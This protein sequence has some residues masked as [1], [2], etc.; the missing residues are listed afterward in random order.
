M[1][2]WPQVTIFYCAHNQ[3]ADF[4]EMKDPLDAA[5]DAVWRLGARPVVLIE[6]GGYV[7]PT[8]RF[9]AERWQ[10]KRE[11]P[12]YRSGIF[13]YPAARAYNYGTYLFVQW[14][15]A[16]IEHGIVYDTPSNPFHK[17]RD[18]YLASRRAKV[19][20]ERPAFSQ[21]LDFQWG[22]GAIQTSVPL[23]AITSNDMDKYYWLFGLCIDRMNRSS[24]VRDR[25]VARQIA[26]LLRE[27]PNCYVFVI[28][29]SSHHFTLSRELS[30]LG[31]RFACYIHGKE[32]PS[33]TVL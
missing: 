32:V 31:I 15:D 5:F 33:T 26:K 11:L 22:L 27:Q 19:I 28:R 17:A 8:S 13:A 3:Q 10:G 12:P 9:N 24:K 6:A 29:G 25:S 30:Q 1:T 7:S 14:V 2:S 20:Y 4:Q 16:D 18:R 23:V 21:I